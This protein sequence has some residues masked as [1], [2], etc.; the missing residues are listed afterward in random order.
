MFASTIVFPDDSDRD[1]ERRVSAFLAER[2]VPAL[3]R[4]YVHSRQGVVTL[5][6][7]VQTFYEKQLSRSVARRVAG[8]VQLVDDVE[9]AS[10]QRP[11]SAP[12]AEGHSANPSR[13]AAATAELFHIDPVS[14]EAKEG[15]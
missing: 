9:V 15:P 14:F 8:V 2:S 4:I 3:R 5:R 10:D 12:A 6:G 11:G 1:L 13:Q 7:H